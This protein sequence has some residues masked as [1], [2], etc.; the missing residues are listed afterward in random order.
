MARQQLGALLVRIIQDCDPERLTKIDLF[1]LTPEV[2]QGTEIIE[3]MSS[4]SLAKLTHVNLDYNH[5]WFGGNENE[6]GQILVDFLGRQTGLQELSLERNYFSSE[7]TDEILSQLVQSPALKTIQKVDLCDSGNFDSD[8]SVEAIAT[9]LATAPVLKEVDIM[10]QKGARDIKASIK[11]ATEATGE[12]A[13]QDT[14]GLVTI[15]NR[16]GNGVIFTLPT[17]KR[18]GGQKVAIRQL[19]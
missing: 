13:N 7:A 12:S 19:N 9:L 6:N 15:T 5:E 11:Y 4:S 3:T 16:Q 18:E 17:E 14:Q 10:F 2:A 1:E 8:A